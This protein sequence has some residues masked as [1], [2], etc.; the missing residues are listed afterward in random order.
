MRRL[1]LDTRFA[2][3]ET[4][5]ADQTPAVKSNRPLSA[6]SPSRVPLGCDCAK[7]AEATRLAAAIAR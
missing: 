6:E 2:A 3:A 1:A 5:P 4:I 7:R